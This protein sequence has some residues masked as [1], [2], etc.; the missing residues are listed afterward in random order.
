MPKSISGTMGLKRGVMNFLSQKNKALVHEL[1]LY[2][3]TVLTQTYPHKIK[4]IINV[5]FELT[6]LAVALCSVVLS[7]R[8]VC[9][10]K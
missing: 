4:T 2:Y 1:I 10:N 8:D 5:N 9:L 7:A 6:S 3:Y